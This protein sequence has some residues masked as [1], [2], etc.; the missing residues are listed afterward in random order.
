MP[1]GRPHI[2][3]DDLRI[4]WGSRVLIE[5]VSFQ[6]ERGTTLA[7]LGGSGSG[8]STLLR[9]LIGLERPLAGR[10]DID[11]V[12]APH[13]YE[14]APPF[15]VLFQSGALFSSLTLAQNLALPLTK[16]TSVRGPA[17]RELCQAKL[18]LVGLGAFADHLPGEIS[19]G[20]KKRA[21][22][23]RAMMLEP[24][25]LFF[26]EP[27]AGLDPI[28]AVEL[29]QLI[30]TLSRDLGIT[31][32]IVTHELPSIFLVANSCI[33][34]DKFAKGIVAR[35]NP[36]DLRDTSDIPFVHN[37]FTRSSPGRAREPA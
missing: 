30:I 4:G 35:G 2:I 28:T 34:L 7:I 3:V 26:D 27:S 1:A 25:L 21:G 32:V 13:V 10:I 11:G 24:D 17:V 18:E 5:H 33:V 31:V 14:G 19:G 23:A 37:F 9:Y 6:I 8:K 36:N 22:I 16:W 20:M 15:G 12:G 29:D